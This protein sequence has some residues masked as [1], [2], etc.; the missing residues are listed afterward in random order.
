MVQ[1]GKMHKIILR[2]IS[3]L[4]T[5]LMP[6]LRVKAQ[7]DYLFSKKKAAKNTKQ[8]E[9]F[10]TEISFLQKTAKMVQNGEMNKIILRK[11][12]P[13]KTKLVSLLRV[14]AQVETCS[15]IKKKLPKKIRNIQVRLTESFVI[16]ISFLQKT[17]KKVQNG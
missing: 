12:L 14:K 4:K 16:E 15:V 3:P 1:N 13:L 6:L 2:K 9:L 5:K 7:V 8:T 17:A 10:I 11:I